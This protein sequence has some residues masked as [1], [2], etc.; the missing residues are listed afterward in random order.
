MGDNMFERLERIIGNE[1]L[2]KLKKS[3][4]LIIGVGGVGG[5]VCEGLA[6]S[7]IE[8]F[9]IID[10]DKVDITNK[11]R[12][13]IALD[14]T[15]G[16]DKVD[17]MKNRLID[18][19]KDINVDTLNIFLDKENTYS[20]ISKYKPDY[21]IDACDTVTTKLE[22]IK[23]CL[24]LNIKFISCM[25]TGNK[26]NPSKLKI[27]DIKNTHTDPLCKVM[28]KLIKENEL[29]GNIDVLWS[30][31]LPI[32]VENRT[33]GSSSFVPSSAGLLIASYVFDKIINNDII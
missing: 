16:L 12:Q 15:I 10:K 1:K 20:I 4:V 14:S 28:R 2:E 18:I 29:K 8:H 17:V 22:I 33:P 30:E 5:Y 24:D 32:K 13:I 7:G 27:T 9:I 19:N 23:A 6:R 11:N 3:T 21:V 25:G 31:E 26:V